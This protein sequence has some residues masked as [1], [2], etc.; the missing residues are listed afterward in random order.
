[1]I[2]KICSDLDSS[3]RMNSNR[4]DTSSF[5]KL[6]RGILVNEFNEDS[7]RSFKE[8]FDELNLTPQIPFIPIYVDSFGGDCYSLLAMLDIIESSQ[9]P[10]ITIAMG[11]AMSCGALLVTLGGASG[12]RFATRNCT[13]MLHDIA[14]FSAGKMEELRSDFREAER[15]TNLMFKLLDQK[16]KKK[17][18]YF[19]NLFGQYKHADIY[20]DATEAKKHNLID[21]IGYPI[22][23]PQSSIELILPETTTVGVPKTKKTS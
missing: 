22:I 4:M 23:V 13:I 14:S 17:S 15:L 2:K 3:F 12:N 21:Q 9:K 1:M 19:K 16:C 10:V 20:F 6:Q 5:D 8:S 18:G 7:V 11:K